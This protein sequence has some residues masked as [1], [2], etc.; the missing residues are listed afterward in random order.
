MRNHNHRP[1]RDALMVSTIAFLRSY[2]RYA[3]RKA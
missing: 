2:A 1:G 3:G